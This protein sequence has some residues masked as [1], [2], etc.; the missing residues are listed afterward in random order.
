MVGEAAVSGESEPVTVP[1]ETPVEMPEGYYDAEVTGEDGLQ[2]AWFDVPVA[3]D[4]T[5]SLDEPF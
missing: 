4:R 3:R 1:P 5:T 2:D